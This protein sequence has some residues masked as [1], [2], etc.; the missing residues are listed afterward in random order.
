MKKKKAKRVGE[1]YVSLI[2]LARKDPE[3]R[4][5]MQ[6]NSLRRQIADVFETS[7]T[8]RGISIRALASMMKTSPSQVQ[9]VLHKEFGGS[10]TLSTIL[11]AADALGF[12]V[13]VK[14]TKKSA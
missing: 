11:R 5:A 6:E 8:N 7:R 4:V 12:D 14:V 9:R 2:C 3:V 13:D 1:S 10:L